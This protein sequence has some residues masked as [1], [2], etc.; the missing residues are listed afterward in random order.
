LGKKPLDADQAGRLRA[1]QLLEVA[2]GPDLAGSGLEAGV[3]VLDF[4]PCLMGLAATAAVRLA[5][6]LIQA[7]R[8]FCCWE[9]TGVVILRV[10]GLGTFTTLGAMVTLN[11]LSQTI[12]I[13]LKFCECNELPSLVC[14]I[15]ASGHKALKQVR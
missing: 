5:R 15:A 2:Q 12:N 6:S 3:H 11:N 4:L 8:A 10:L 13:S 1:R 14:R 9:T 7:L